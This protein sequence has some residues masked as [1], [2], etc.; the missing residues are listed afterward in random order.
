MYPFKPVIVVN[1]IR[2]KRSCSYDCE[3]LGICGV[4]CFCLGWLLLANAGWAEEKK[5][6]ILVIL[7]DD[8]GYSDLGCYGGEI[9]T[10]NI[11]RLA[12]NGARF[13]NFYNSARC[14]PS[15]A[16]LMTGLYPT[17]AGIGDFTTP[18]PAANKGPGYLGRLRNDCVTIAEVLK[19]VGYR[20]YY[21]GKWHMHPQTGPIDRGFDEFYG[22]T[23]DHS[24]DQF[25]KGYYERLP[26]DHP[27]EIDPPEQDFYATDV[28]N[29]YA[30]EFI[31]QGRRS[32]QPW[33]LFLGHSSPHFPLQ[34]P[35]ERIDR[36]YE[37]Y[38]QG[39][40]TL[41]SRRFDR[42]KQLGLL[43]ETGQ[44]L[45]VRSEVPVDEERIANGFAGQQNPAWDSL[46]K[47]RQ[48]DLARRM[49]VY[50][51]MVES[52]DRGVGE[53]VKHLENTDELANT[54]ILMLSDNG[55][56]Y[57][58]GPFGFDGV[59]RKGETVLYSDSGLD[60]VGGRGTHSS[61]GSAWANLSNTP[62]R[63]YKHFTYE[64]GIGT[65]MIAHWPGRIS[66]KVGWIRAPSHL[67]DLMPTILEATGATYPTSWR[68]ESIQPL[69]GVSLF[70][71]MRGEGMEDR[72]LGFEHQGARAL[73]KGIWKTVWT[74]RVPHT[75]E[76]ELFNLA[77]DPY[78]QND[79]AKKYPE[80]LH[81]LVLEWDR[82][83]KRVGVIW[84][85]RKAE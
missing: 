34:A 74:K 65:P 71:A 47:D 18:K 9:S 6:N 12:N 26:K 51:A 57:E 25:D 36:Y 7:A 24:H 72:A 83:A 79:L 69:E 80:K 82:W 16:S 49:A 2:L 38:L 1:D 4:L 28:F 46:D 17:Q 62:L 52:I 48:C 84:E 50:A 70:P 41:R 10:P 23:N 8:L 81:E 64:G 20:C 3:P 63:S 44:P 59:S 15:R 56:C 30:L 40:D 67:M 66:Q 77:E 32:E 22:Y 11:D 39:W 31:Q 29:R 55:A 76:W 61:Y 5:P 78:E 21:V 42:M 19:P 27:K 14:C 58:W 75:V 33:F 37:M 45:P 68:N 73:R 43:R 35:K 60:R 53:L 13:T 54:L 85:E